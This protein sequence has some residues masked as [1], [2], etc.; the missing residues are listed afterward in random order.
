MNE[1]LIIERALENLKAATKL[2]GKWTAYEDNVFDGELE[3]LFGK[4]K[5]RFLIEI[6]KELRNH[7]LVQL[8][9]LPRA[10][11]PLVIIA[12]H[13]FPKIKEELKNH[14]IGY[15]ETNGNMYLNYDPVFIQIEGRKDLPEGNE[16]KNRAFTKTGLK[17]IFMLLQD[18]TILNQP[19]REI[20]RQAGIALGN[21]NYILNGL[22]QDGFLIAIENQKN[23]LVNKTQLLDKW[24]EGYNEK[25]KP[26]LKVG[27]FR[28]KNMTDKNEWQ[29]IK[30][31]PG[32]TF[33]G[34]EAGGA[35]LTGYLKPQELIIYTTETRN[36]LIK[37]YGLI[38]DPNGNIKVFRKFWC[39][40]QQM[41]QI[42]PPLLVYTDL[43][44]TGDGRCFETAKL[45]YEKFQ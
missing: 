21:I 9:N 30:F 15:M 10:D 25:L 23:M 7:Q 12:D 24:I 20:A 26:G 35:K 5:I 44:N 19:Y 34:G 11:K 40:P 16:K 43:M 31:K 39:T 17:V 29:K 45:I 36:E 6:R 18:E 2:N 28:L 27:T 38:P 8:I 3:L 13:I 1:P 4:Q 41:E 33:W 32:K 37:N 22:K 42:A 14:D